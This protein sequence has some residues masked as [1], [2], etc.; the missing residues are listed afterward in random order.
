MIAEA[1]SHGK[2]CSRCGAAHTRIGQRYCCSCHAA[3][4]RGWRRGRP[5][6]ADQ[7]RKDNVRSHANVAKR[8]GQ[9]TQAA[10]ADCGDPNSQ[11][12]HPDYDRPLLVVWLCRPCHLARH[13]EAAV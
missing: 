2:H 1:L 12:H 3:Y 13:A 6:T 5:L 10:C 9:L 11:M 7:R 8:R 4:M